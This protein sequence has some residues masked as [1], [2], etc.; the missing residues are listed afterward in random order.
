MK[1]TI[2]VYLENE[3]VDV[4]RPVEAWKIDE[5]RYLIPEET[6]IPEDEEWQFRPGS[7]VRCA[8]KKMFEA[9]CLVAIDEQ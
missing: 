2:Y 7:T 8:Q 4:W 3:G 6:P 1:T 9:E 5:E